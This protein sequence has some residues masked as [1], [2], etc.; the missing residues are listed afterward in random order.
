MSI[1]QHFLKNL[2]KKN[3]KDVDFYA[4]KRENTILKKSKK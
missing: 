2:I 1:D 4:D 3:L